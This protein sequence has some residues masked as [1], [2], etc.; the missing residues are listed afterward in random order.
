MPGIVKADQLD[1]MDEILGSPS[2]VTFY[3]SEME[4]TPSH[5][6]P[7]LPVCSV[8][9]VL[10]WRWSGKSGR[11]PIIQRTYLVHALK[12]P[13]HMLTAPVIYGV[14]TASTV[15]GQVKV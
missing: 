12:N 2:L 7:I 14:H 1:S 15:P 8:E 11:P 6:S 10:R 5:R 13:F 9:Y 3:L 4:G